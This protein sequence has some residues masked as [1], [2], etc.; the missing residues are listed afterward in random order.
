MEKVI[1]RET[2]SVPQH[3]VVKALAVSSEFD[4]YCRVIYL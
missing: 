2:F 4:R 3:R 1:L